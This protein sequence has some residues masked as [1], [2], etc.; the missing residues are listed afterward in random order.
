VDYVMVESR[1]GHGVH[2]VGRY[3]V[4]RPV[5]RWIW[6][7]SDGSGLIREIAGPFSFFK[8]EGKARWE[9]AGSPPLR[10][11]LSDDV[12]RPGGLRGAASRLAAGR[13]D[14]A[15][16]WSVLTAR[17][18]RS[19]HDLSELLGETI[20]PVDVRHAAYGIASRLPEIDIR[21]EIADQLGRR[22]H[23]LVELDAN[24]D[25]RELVF[26]EDYELLGYQV[27]L[28]DPHADYAA[29]GTVISWASYLTRQW[30]DRL[31]PDAPPIPTHD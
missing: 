16:A 7:G 3:D 25:R 19:L 23:G 8:P 29:P 2:A 9:T 13:D 4:F 15:T 14:P 28:L 22:G 31:P 18:P 30:A 10:E 27:T 1:G 20:L 6:V 17:P 12:F 24:G 21:T 26:S 11:G 5:H